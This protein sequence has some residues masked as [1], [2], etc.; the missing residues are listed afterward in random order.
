MPAPFLT[1]ELN[2][3]TLDDVEL[4]S[5]SGFV[6]DINEGVISVVYAPYESLLA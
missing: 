6:L 4:I 2:E 5:A 3:M 1:V